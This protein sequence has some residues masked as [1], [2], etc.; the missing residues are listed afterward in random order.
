MKDSI[1]ANIIYVNKNTFENKKTGEV[2]DYAEFKLLVP[3]EKRKGS[4]S[5]GYDVLRFTTKAE[6]YAVLVEYLNANEPLEITFKYSR[7]Y[8]GTSKEKFSR[9]VDTINGK[10]L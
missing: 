3:I 4:Y 10:T 9:K 5:I 1:K 2:V 6:N 8:D 7:L